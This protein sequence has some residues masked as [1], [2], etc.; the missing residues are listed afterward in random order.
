DLVAAFLD[1]DRHRAVLARLDAEQRA[2]LRQ[3]ERVAQPAD[4]GG[5]IARRLLA[6]IEVL[7]ELLVARRKHRAVLPVDAG[8]ILLAVEPGERVAVAGD[9]HHVEA[10]SMAVALLVGADRHL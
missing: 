4:A 9:A 10:R 1:V 8:E 2:A 6:R 7:V 3:R 5:E